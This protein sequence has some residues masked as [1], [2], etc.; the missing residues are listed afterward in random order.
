[1]LTIRAAQMSALEND[2][3]F[4]WIADFLLRNY[5][6]EI[7]NGTTYREEILSSMKEAGR[8]GLTAGFEVRK[9]VHV[10]YLT[11]WKLE[12]ADEYAWARELLRD[13]ERG[14]PGNRLAALESRIRAKI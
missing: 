1:M 9:Y 12:S 13:E 2:Q 5:S 10:A 11:G 4:R 3:L 6:H 8:R 14:D 7:P